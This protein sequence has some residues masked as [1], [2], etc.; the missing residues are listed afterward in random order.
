MDTHSFA[1]LQRRLTTGQAPHKAQRER[2]APCFGLMM[3]MA[4]CVDC[5][6]PGSCPNRP[7]PRKNPLQRFLSSSRYSP[8]KSSVVPDVCC[9]V[10]APP[11]GSTRVRSNCR[12]SPRTPPPPAAPARRGWPPRLRHRRQARP[13]HAAASSRGCAAWQAAAAHRSCRRGRA[14]LRL[15]SGRCHRHG[16]AIAAAAAGLCL[17]RSPAVVDHLRRSPAVVDHHHGSVRPLRWGTPRRPWLSTSSSPRSTRPPPL[18]TVGQR[19]GPRPRLRPPRP[20]SRGRRTASPCAG[21]SCGRRA[22]AR[23]P[24]PRPA[25]ATERREPQPARANS[26]SAAAAGSRASG[27]SRGRR[28]RARPPPPWPER[29]LV[30]GAAA[31]AREFNL[32]RRGRPA[33]EREGAAASAQGSQSPRLVCSTGI[34][35]RDG[36]GGGLGAVAA[37]CGGGGPGKGGR[38]PREGGRPARLGSARPRRPRALRSQLHPLLA[39]AAGVRGGAARVGVEMRERGGG[40]RRLSDRGWEDNE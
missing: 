23:P 3:L 1:P 20:A 27:G 28:A 26:T 32:R 24:P 34:R 38:P 8:S 40:G 30:E 37:A 25:R 36:G 12:V 5:T 33:R 17:R 35:R 4:D 22:R 21:G 31:G 18:H 39:M 6:T 13:P 16:S 11:H 15:A 10:A 7:D 19:S 14:R 29:E 2:G 9:A